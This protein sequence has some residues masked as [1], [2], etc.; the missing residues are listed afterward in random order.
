MAAT[1]NQAI[2]TVCIVVPTY[3]EAENIRPLLNT[4]F[5]HHDTK[6]APLHVLVVDDNSPDG[7]AKVVK[8]YCENNKNVHLLL[9]KTKDGLGAAYIAGMQH[10]MRLLDPDI[11]VEMDADLSHNPA[12]VYKMLAKIRNGADF[13]IGSRYVKGGEIPDDWGAR[14]KIISTLANIMTRTLL[15][16]YKVRDCSG[17]YRAMRTSY[18]KQID[19]SRLSVKGYAFQAVLLEAYI[20]EGAVIEETPIAFSDR[21]KGQS[22]MRM[23]DVIE[24]FT[25]L[26]AI[27]LQRLMNKNP[28]AN[29]KVDSTPSSN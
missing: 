7:T 14:R 29:K 2:G 13:V 23:K 1:K 24:G 27:R 22:K 3:N 12:D 16:T 21:N 28:H 9:R 25:A 6:D 17:G 10:A 26:S 8:E 18:L 11:I 5:S 4:I 15:G 20:Y 19:L